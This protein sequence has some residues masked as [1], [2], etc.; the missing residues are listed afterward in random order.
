MQNNTPCLLCTLIYGWILRL[1]FKLGK[2]DED[3]SGEEPGSQECEDTSQGTVTA[4]GMPCNAIN[5]ELI[6]VIIVISIP[7]LMSEV[8]EELDNQIPSSTKPEGGADGVLDG[9]T[10][11]TCKLSQVNLSL[12]LTSY[13]SDYC[14]SQ[15]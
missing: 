12:Q 3:A 11:I 4:K 9:P 10:T 2:E 5:L 14:R 8:G 7:G 6:P 15:T 13:F 1:I